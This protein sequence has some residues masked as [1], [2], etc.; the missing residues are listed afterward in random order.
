MPPTP[1]H[2]S[3]NNTSR[4]NLNGFKRSKLGKVF[5]AGSMFI[6][7][8]TF[9]SWESS[10]LLSTT[11]ES[12]RTR[13]WTRDLKRPL[14]G[15]SD[16]G[17][18]NPQRVPTSN[19]PFVFFLLPMCGESIRESTHREIF[20]SQTEKLGKEAVVPCYGGIPCSVTE[21]DIKPTYKQGEETLSKKSSCADVFAGHFTSDLIP[22]LAALDNA[23]ITRESWES[24]RD[25]SCEPR[26]RDL[27]PSFDC[28]VCIREPVARFVS[29]YYH[30]ITSED[31]R[32]KDR[33]IEDL[34]VSEL[35][36]ILESFGTNI[37]TDYLSKHTSRI[38]ETLNLG[39]KIDE[40]A[41]FL[42]TCVIGV[43]EEWDSSAALIESAFPWLEG[44]AAKAKEEQVVEGRGG[45]KPLE[46]LPPE[47][48]NVLKSYLDADLQLYAQAVKKFKAQLDYFGIAS[49]KT[50]S[51]SDVHKQQQ[52]EQES[53]NPLSDSL[54]TPAPTP[55]QLHP[56]V[57]YS[58]EGPQTRPPTP[59]S[60]PEPLPQWSRT[61]PRI[62]VVGVMKCGTSHMYQ[63]TN[64]AAHFD[65][66]SNLSH[67]LALILI[68]G[69][70]GPPRRTPSQQTYEGMVP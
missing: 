47:L 2:P 7:V 46:D 60:F 1:T 44:Y 63:V 45:Q 27:E 31:I 57:P 42:G 54:V 23:A 67:P 64:Y 52:K 34:S 13:S 41:R 70:G 20:Y 51:V 55:V 69:F 19:R 62:N 29:Q 32:F 4:L 43:I 39:E 10:F 3:A 9:L 16:S 25:G 14:G 6:F 35:E 15:V 37:M 66:Q 53:S 26:W 28:L 56:L 24:D 12:I 21:E 38:S 11:H 61:F 22:S 58:D 40:A 50:D 36:G 59:S 17:F 48:A 18:P 8:T 68:S 33:A 5:I 30:F 65:F 49:A